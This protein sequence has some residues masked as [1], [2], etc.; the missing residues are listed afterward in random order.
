MRMTGSPRMVKRQPTG[1][2]L[3]SCMNVFR[4]GCFSLRNGV[5]PCEGNSIGSFP[6]VPT[7]QQ[8]QNLT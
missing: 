7:E 8:L 2:N 3:S 5:C 4:M 1:L 6:P